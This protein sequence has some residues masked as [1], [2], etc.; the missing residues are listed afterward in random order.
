MALAL[1]LEWPCAARCRLPATLPGYP[2]PT[3]HP[4]PPTHTRAPSP[5][6]DIVDKLL[7]AGYVPDCV[8]GP[9][10]DGTEGGTALHLAAAQGCEGAAHALLRAGA[11]PRLLDFSARNALDLAVLHGHTRLVPPLLEAGC[12]FTNGSGGWGVGAAGW[13]RL[14]GDR[15]LGWLG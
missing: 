10:A 3:H 2:P 6:A 12:W 13:G 5:P 14:D 15:C 9:L 1:L 4:H 7:L 8:A 11:D